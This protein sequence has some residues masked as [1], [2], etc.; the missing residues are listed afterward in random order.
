L[1]FLYG[2]YHPV[3]L[4]IFDPIFP[5]RSFFEM[6]LL[7]SSAILCICRVAQLVEHRKTDHE[8]RGD[9]NRKHFS[10]SGWCRRFDSGPCNLIN[11]TLAAIIPLVKDLMRKRLV[12]PVRI[13]LKR[14]KKCH[15][16]GMPTAIIR[17]L[18]V[19]KN[20]CILYFERKEKQ[21]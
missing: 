14:K 20:E 19:K 21:T 12:L 17:F 2:R 8:K 1:L 18:M 11:V 16:L 4:Y 13:R 5:L 3:R 7:L 9:P 6:I 15:D 10:L